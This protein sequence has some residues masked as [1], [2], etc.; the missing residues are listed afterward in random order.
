M[1]M[2]T[3]FFLAAALLLPLSASADR[4]D[5][6]LAKGPVVLIEQDGE[7]KFK[8]STSIIRIDAPLDTVWKAVLDLKNYKTFM[9]KT[10]RSDVA[11]QTETEAE[12]TFE[13]DVPFANPVYTLHYQFDAKE[14]F[15]QISWAKGDLKGSYYG[16]KF[17]PAGDST[18]IYY[19][20]STKKY[21]S[22][23]EQLE[24]DQQTIT[25]GINVASQLAVLRALKQ[26]VEKG[27]V[28]IGP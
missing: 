21:S 17:V 27:Q 8:S 6:L 19:K 22:W 18:L 13:V 26:H 25:V 4:L 9:P 11:F 5:D 23:A 24:D 3:G 28:K 2:K 15:I 1:N 12:V 20:G 7:A 14:R 16:W 10:L